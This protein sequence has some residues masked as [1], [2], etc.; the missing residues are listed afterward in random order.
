MALTNNELNAE[1]GLI[2][3]FKEI[4]L[5]GRQA[6]SLPDNDISK[7]EKLGVQEQGESRLQVSARLTSFNFDLMDL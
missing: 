6:K 4:Q 3:Y 5:L 2:K 1:Q 7:I